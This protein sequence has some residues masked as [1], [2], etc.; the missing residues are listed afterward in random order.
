MPLVLPTHFPGVTHMKLA[1]FYT[2][3]AS[4]L[5]ALIVWFSVTFIGSFL[6]AYIGNFVR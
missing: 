4:I 3:I 1:C 6:G 5:F 2:M